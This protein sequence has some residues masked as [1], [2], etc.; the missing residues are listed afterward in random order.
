M[1]Q[2]FVPMKKTT[3]A[4]VR[5]ED[6][7]ARVFRALPHF[8]YT[9]LLPEMDDDE[10]DV[11]DKMAMVQHLLVAA[12]RYSMDDRLKILSEDKLCSCIDTQARYVLAVA[13]QH[14]CKGL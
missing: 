12:D 13:E 7:E 14:G 9:D 1:A 3:L 4:C 5:I 11:D 2:L 6:M 10:R 8:V